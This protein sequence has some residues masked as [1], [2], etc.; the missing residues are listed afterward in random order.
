MA[1]AGLTA[2]S[3]FFTSPRRG[4]AAGSKPVEITFSSAKFFG[5]ETIAEVAEAFNSSQD[6]IHVTLQRTASAEFF[7]GG[8]SGT[9][10]AACEAQR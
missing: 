10:A 2:A 9:R 8:A 6:K 5:K 1:V 3:T 7:H 4:F